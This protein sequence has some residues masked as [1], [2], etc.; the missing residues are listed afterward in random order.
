VRLDDEQE[1]SNIEDRRGFSPGG[2]IIGG[3]L[4][5]AGLALVAMFFGIDPRVVLQLGEQQARSHPTTEQHRAK[6]PDSE[7]ERE[8]TRFV[9]RVLGSTETTWGEIFARNQR[10]YEKPVLVLFT[11]QVRSACG[12]ASAAV[13]PFYCGGDH[14]VYIDLAFY[15]DLRTRFHA[16]GEFAQAY[17]IAHEVGHH[18]QNLLGVM[19]RVNG[20]R[21]RVSEREAN[22]LSV[23]LELQADCF[24]GVWAHHADRERHILEDGD[25]AA[26]L[27]AASQIGDD[28]LQMQARGYVSPESFTHGSSA[29]RVR[30]FRTGLDSGDLK[31]CDT[32]RHRERETAGG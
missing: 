7:A 13:G 10:H 2:G 22:A 4:G 17:V 1:S 14:K 27:N 16:P 5:L 15:H 8:M 25:I 18:V 3:G 24:A 20:L 31:Q 21:Q 32:F 12:L 30:W 29:Q 23:R 26:G 9:A 19:S 6:P 28:R 11:G